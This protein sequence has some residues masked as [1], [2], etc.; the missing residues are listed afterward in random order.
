MARVV[1][2]EVDPT[3]LFG[4]AGSDDLTPNL[5]LLC[6]PTKALPCVGDEVKALMLPLSVDVTKIIMDAV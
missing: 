3:F 1:E 4:A 6:D 5:F 2:E